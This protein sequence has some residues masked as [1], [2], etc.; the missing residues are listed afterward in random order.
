M[1]NIFL[2]PFK[3]FRKKYFVKSNI[4]G[5]ICTGSLILRTIVLEYF[6]RLIYCYMRFFVK[7]R[8]YPNTKKEKSSDS[9]IFFCIGVKSEKMAIFRTS[10]NCLF[11]LPF[12]SAFFFSFGVLNRPYITISNTS[13]QLIPGTK[14]TFS[15]FW[16]GSKNGVFR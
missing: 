11:L 5:M 2:P 16:S 8:F 6:N 13:L 1:R 4:W 10:E 3:V 9:E 15:F 7:F 12:S 14:S